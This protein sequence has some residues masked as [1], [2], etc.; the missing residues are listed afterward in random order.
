[1]GDAQATAVH[2]QLGID[3]HLLSVYAAGTFALMPPREPP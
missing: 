2:C 3:D 1:M